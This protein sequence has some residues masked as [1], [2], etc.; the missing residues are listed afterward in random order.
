MHPV[1]RKR[2]AKCALGLGNFIFM[3]RKHQVSAAAMDVER[4]AKIFAAHRRT[5]DMPAR[6][7]RTPG[8]FPTRLACLTRLP[9]SEIQR[10]FLALIDFDASPR[11]QFLDSFARKLAISGETRNGEEHIAISAVGQLPLL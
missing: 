6:T 9:E 7:A 11:F 8:T 2:Q 10:G 4:L 3:M 1:A 5:L